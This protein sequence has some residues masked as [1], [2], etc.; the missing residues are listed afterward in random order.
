MARDTELA[1]LHPVVREKIFQLTQH[2]KAEQLPF[3]LFEGFRSPD[4]Q[5]DLYAQGRTKPGSKVTNAQAWSSY[6]QYGVAGD[7]V[8]YEN[9]RWSWDDK[10]ERKQWWK[11]L[12]VLARQ[13]GLEP[14]SWETPHLQLVGISLSQLKNGQYPPDG[15]EDW[16]DNLR[17][18]IHQWRGSPAAP[19]EPAV[20]FDRPALDPSTVNDN[21]EIF[22]PARSEQPKFRV[23]AR[24]GLR[25]REGPGTAYDIVATLSSGQVVTVVAISGEWS[26]VDIE[27]DG[28]ADGYCHSGYLAPLS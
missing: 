1:H 22:S 5:R 24:N 27:G 9:G 20:I 19:P 8:L 11:Q 15:D 17:S 7:F 23:T 25:M 18:A 16:A 13:V 21:R 2:L 28:L 26:Q 10:G 3:R 12:H 14:L 4:R 6:H